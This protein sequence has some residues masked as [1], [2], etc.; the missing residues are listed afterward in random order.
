[1]S[2]RIAFF[3][4]GFAFNRLVRMKFY[5]KVFPKNVELYLI[6]TDK[7][8]GKENESYQQNYVL[9]RTKVIKLNY[10]SLKLPFE[11]RRVCREN[12]IDKIINL[13]FHT[14]GIA[15]FL[16]TIF[17]KTDYILNILTDIFN[18]YCLVETK[19]ESIKEL[20]IL[21]M[22][23]PLVYFAKRVMFTD[24]LDYKRAP[25]FFISQKS[26]MRWLAAPVNTNLFVIKNKKT[27]R[28][29]LHIGLNKKIVLFV[30]RINYLKCSDILKE[31]IEKNKDIHFI[32]IGRLM[33]K[34]IAGLK[35]KNFEI[36]ESRS[37]KELVDYYNAADF[38]FCVNRGGGGIGLVTEEALACG[39]PVIVSKEFRL[40]DSPA[41]FQSAVNFD[42][43][44]AK[45]REF[46]TLSEKEKKKLSLTARKYAKD[47]YSDESWKD[48]YIEAYLG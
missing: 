18:Q 13:G 10:H 38:S 16:A 22:M 33:D 30:G 41:V 28:K 47:N 20:L 17:S 34:R 35:T 2:K 29:K 11:L 21:A 24:Y 1:M 19:K 27:A 23:F 14:G 6:T 4:V 40:K 8:K 46:F 7:Y 48:K 42:E 43:I 26:K 36:I 39:C 32:L 5:E 15:L 9:S 44:N 3:T 25:V 45:I 37:S 31:L 12:K